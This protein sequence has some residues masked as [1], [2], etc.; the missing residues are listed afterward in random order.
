MTTFDV[1]ATPIIKLVLL[2][3]NISALTILYALRVSSISLNYALILTGS[4][5][6]ACYE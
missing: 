3:L 2:K 4:S 1:E 5:Y 6:L